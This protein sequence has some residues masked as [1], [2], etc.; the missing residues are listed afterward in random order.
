MNYYKLIKVPMGS[1]KIFNY[2][3][4]YLS[5]QEFQWDIDVTEDQIFSR[6]I[7]RAGH[8]SCCVR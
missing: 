1:N 5:N 6:R 2:K 8:P 4:K 3:K 7:K